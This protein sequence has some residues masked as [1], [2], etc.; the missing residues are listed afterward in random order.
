MSCTTMVHWA[1]KTHQHRNRPVAGHR[2]PH[3]AM[4]PNQSVNPNQNLASLAGPHQ[5][6]SLVKCAINRT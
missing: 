2:H 5:H 4:N 1:V 3:L 6:R